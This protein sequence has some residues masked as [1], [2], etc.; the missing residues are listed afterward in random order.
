MDRK[1]AAGKQAQSE[2]TSHLKDLRSTLA[3]LKDQGDVIE[4]DQ[5]VDPDLQLT[6]LQKLMDGGP[7]ALFSKVKGKPDHR[8]LTN[9]FGSIEIMNKMFAW[10]NDKERTVKLAQ[11]LNRPIPPVEIS[12][13]E[14]PCQEVVIERPKNV[15][16]HI[17][18]IRHTELEKEL[19]VG[20][21]IRCLSGAVFAGGTDTGYNRMNFRWGNVGTFQVSPGSHMWQVLSDAH[22]KRE[23]IPIT[24]CF[25]TPPACTLLA[26]AAFDYVI[27][28]H[29]CDELGIAGAAQGFPVRLVKARTVDAMAMAALRNR[30]SGRSAEA[31]P[32]PFPS[33]MGG[34][35]GQVL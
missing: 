6:G 22:R 18:P 7:P 31:R 8:L 32:L 28:P 34:L 4:T 26:G 25:G 15:Y 33:R 16:D 29:G 30:R 14:A 23:Q 11:A 5:E 17:V 12:Q 10:E 35:Y 20:S 9:L 13:S 19:T 21:G 24:M 3:F 2:A 27:L 1:S